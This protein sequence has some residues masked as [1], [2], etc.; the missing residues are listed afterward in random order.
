MGDSLHV[1]VYHYW[2]CVNHHIFGKV[3]HTDC[4]APGGQQQ[5]TP[6]GEWLI[7]CKVNTLWPSDATWRH[8]SGSTLAQ[9]MA[10]CLTAPSHYLNQCWLIINKVQWSSFE[11]NFLR[12]TSATINKNYHENYIYKISLKSS[13]DQW[14]NR[15][16]TSKWHAFAT[17]FFSIEIE[18]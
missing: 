2:F 9:V 1:K 16:S 7:V 15:H 6:T 12:H 14:V 8:R 13:R 5:E 3:S 4:S 11:G 10:C 17:Y 18:Y